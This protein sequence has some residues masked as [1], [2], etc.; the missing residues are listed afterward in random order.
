MKSYFNI[1]YRNVI[2]T[3]NRK[4][5]YSWVIRI[6]SDFTGVRE[7]MYFIDGTPSTRSAYL[8]YRNSHFELAQVECFV[9]KALT[10]HGYKLK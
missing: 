3:A 10:F 1:L 7:P 4:E 9:Q 8:L 6:L 2:I 5:T